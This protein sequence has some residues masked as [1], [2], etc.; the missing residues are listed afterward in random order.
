M[1]KN[2]SL[3]LPWT[4]LLKVEFDPLE[5]ELV[6]VQPSPVGALILTQRHNGG[7]ASMGS[8]FLMC[9]QACICLCA[10]DSDIWDIFFI[11][12]AQNTLGKIMTY[13]KMNVCDYISTLISFNTHYKHF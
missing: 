5:M 11:E 3:V 8:F 12:K 2:K 1:W 6:M 4:L 10:M 9:K 7:H 13:M